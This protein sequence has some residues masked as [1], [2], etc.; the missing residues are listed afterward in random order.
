MNHVIIEWS[1]EWNKAF[2]FQLPWQLIL[3]ACKPYCPCV[4]IE[5]HLPYAKQ[6]HISSP[7]F[8]TN[9]PN[10]TYTRKALNEY[11][12]IISASLLVINIKLPVQA[13]L[14][15]SAIFLLGNAFFICENK[16]FD[17]TAFY[18]EMCHRIWLY[19]NFNSEIIARILTNNHLLSFSALQFQ[20]N[21]LRTMI[22]IEN[23]YFELGKSCTK[24]CLIICDRGVMDASACK[25][26]PRSIRSLCVT[27]MGMKMNA[28]NDF[29][30]VY[31]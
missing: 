22:Q 10:I 11:T 23:T 12:H 14:L 9:A 5:V 25:L 28:W 19:S 4:E 8:W 13:S 1:G 31:I 15:C 24:N 27:L 26:L 6:W 2:Q 17:L 29:S 18:L 21:L 16:L 20:E 3:I 30:T 7:S